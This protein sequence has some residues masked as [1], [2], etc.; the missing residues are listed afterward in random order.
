MANLIDFNAVELIDVPADHVMPGD[1]FD[2]RCG[3]GA[4]AFKRV[5]SV[6]YTDD[7][8][9]NGKDRVELT[10]DVPANSWTPTREMFV[11]VTVRLGRPC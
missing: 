10:F 9:P 5:V 4:L 6:R 11:D 8:R 2:T 1:W 3:L 7:N